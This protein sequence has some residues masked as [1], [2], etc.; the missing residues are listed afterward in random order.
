MRRR[1]VYIS[2]RGKA[3]PL[4]APRF[5]PRWTA[6]ALLCLSGCLLAPAATPAQ[7]RALSAPSAVRSPYQVTGWNTYSLLF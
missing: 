3:L 7:A 5:A 4:S 2:F 1:P 6:P